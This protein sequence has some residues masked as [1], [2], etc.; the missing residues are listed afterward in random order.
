MRTAIC[1]ALVLVPAV[2]AARPKAGAAKDACGAKILPLAVGNTWTYTSIPSPL[3][4]TDQI[5]RI[6]PTQPKTIVVT[7]KD[8]AANKGETVVTLEEKVT[9]DRTTDP[10]KPQVD[11]F[12]Y[13]STITC[14]DKKFDISPNSYFFAGEPGGVFGLEITQLDRVNG[15]SLKL[16]KKGGIG[17]QLWG[18]DLKMTWTR[19]PTEGSG[20]QLG[21]GKLELERRFTPQ[22]P[23]Q[24]TTHQGVYRSEKI[25][26]VTTGRVTLDNASPDTK[27]M[28]LPANWISQLWMADGV[29]V[30]QT[31]NSYAQMYQLTESNVK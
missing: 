30:V 25:G 17:D 6:S 7:V 11:E 5:K 2:A 31:L 29:G 1:A 27:P 18:E 13:T 28:E 20:A 22:E 14:N 3:P 16:T 24:V 15:T 9:V 4:P 21:S 26:L 10:K 12:S 23:E 8:V 19:K